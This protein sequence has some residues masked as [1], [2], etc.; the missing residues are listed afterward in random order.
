MTEHRPTATDIEH[1]LVRLGRQ[2]VS[3][4]LVVAS[5]GNI[6][7]RRPDGLLAVTP[8][9][10]SLAGCQVDDLPLLDGDGTQVAGAHRPTS[11]WLMHTEAMRRR[12]DVTVGLHLHPATSTTLHALGIPVRHLTTDHAYY[13]REVATVGFHPPGSAELAHAVA[14]A[15]D[16]SDVVLLRNHGCM[17][18]ADSVDLA[19]SR[20]ANLEAA[21]T[22]T[23]LA[24]QLNDTTT[25]V[26]DAYLARVRE[27]E[28]AAGR[29][30]YGAGAAR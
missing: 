24:L 2:V 4:G 17:V 18:L 26:P 13:L 5:G 11:E 21:A 25:T 9:G 30:V 15:I 7:V 8:S 16:G 10:W 12:P 22:A 14:E 19:Y 6:S 20:A 23:L 1:G 29:A 27:A 3:T 28:E